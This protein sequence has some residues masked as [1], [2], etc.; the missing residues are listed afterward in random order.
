MFRS[1]KVKNFR[2]ITDLRVDGLSRVNLFVGHNACGKTT[3]LESLFFLIGATNPKLPVSVSSFRG[4]PYISGALWP[5]YFHNMDVTIPIEISAEDSE[6]SEEQLLLIRPRYESSRPDQDAFPPTL[7][8]GWVPTGP[9]KDGSINGLELEYCVAADPASKRTSSVFL[10]DD[11]LVDEARQ[12]LGGYFGFYN[13]DRPHQALAYRT[14]AEVHFEVDVLKCN[15]VTG[16]HKKE[17]EAKRKKMLLLQNT[18]LKNGE[19]GLDNREY[20][21]LLHR[22][23]E[24]PWD[25]SQSDQAVSRNRGSGAHA[26]TKENRRVLAQLVEREFAKIPGSLQHDLHIPGRPYLLLTAGVRR[27]FQK[28]SVVEIHRK[29]DIPLPTLW[30]IAVHSHVFRAPHLL[31]C[32]FALIRPASVSP[33]QTLSSSAFPQPASLPDATSRHFRNSGRFSETVVGQ[34]EGG[35][36]AGIRCAKYWGRV[37]HRSR[38]HHPRHEGR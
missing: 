38:R 16:V 28:P 34:A 27:E 23:H 22:V 18:T 19:S 10:R 4:F 13:T 26:K 37:A 9:G 3:L 36:Y 8:T 24:S 21:I 20:L 15:K 1:V 25:T 29:G 17:K 5:T 35:A 12:G 33:V 30:L 14:P 6:T 31:V 32:K 11:K 7:S 2:A